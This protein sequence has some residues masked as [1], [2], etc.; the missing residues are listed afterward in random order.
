MEI[1]WNCLLLEFIKGTVNVISSKPFFIMG[2]ADFC[3][4]GMSCF[5]F[6]NEGS[7]EITK[8]VPLLMTN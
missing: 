8:T 2:L 6:L 3:E 7:V 1:P 5:F 4:P